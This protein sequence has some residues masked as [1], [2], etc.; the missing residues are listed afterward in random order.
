MKNFLKKTGW[1][2]VIVAIIFALIGIFMIINP[3]SATKIISYIIGGIF[4]VVG[5]I[6]IVNYYIA[7]GDYDF[8]NYDLLYGI[9]AIIIGVITIIYSG[10]IESM[11]RIM[12]GIW[13][14]YT[15]LLRLSMSLKLHKA[16]ADIWIMSLI[17][18]IIMIIGGIYIILQN[19]VLILTVGIIM[20]VYSVIDLIESIIFIKNVNELFIEE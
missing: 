14:I 15:G 13:I 8:Y 19:G 9:I 11:L 20:L 12:I 10:L 5:I 16:D 3:D 7:K 2:D 17:L 6:R 4:I 1:T 18:S